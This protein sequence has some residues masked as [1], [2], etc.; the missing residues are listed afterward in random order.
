[1]AS[2]STGTGTTGCAFEQIGGDHP[3]VRLG[4]RSVQHGRHLRAWPQLLRVQ[5][6][7]GHPVD[8]PTRAN[9]FKRRRVHR[10]LRHAL[11]RRIG[12]VA[13]NTDA[14]LPTAGLAAALPLAKFSLGACFRYLGEMAHCRSQAS[15]STVEE[16]VPF[17]GDVNVALSVLLRELRRMRLVGSVIPPVPVASI[18]GLPLSSSL[19]L[20]LVGLKNKPIAQVGESP[21][22]SA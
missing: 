8:F 15:T 6:P 11:T 16:G 21:P 10:Q 2:A 13:R 19:R 9:P 22:H 7:V 5:H 12:G 17:S 18:T 3:G 4:G 20:P 1:M 14:L